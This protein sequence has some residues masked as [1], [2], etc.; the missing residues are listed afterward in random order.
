[1]VNHPADGSEAVN[2]TYKLTDVADW[3]KRPEVIVGIPLIKMRVDEQSK[4]V[5]G[6]TLQLSNKGWD[7]G[8]LYW[9]ANQ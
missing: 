6:A 5:R 8:H 7:V 9:D 3:A 4:R 2:W 1:M